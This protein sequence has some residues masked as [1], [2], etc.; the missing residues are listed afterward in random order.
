[1]RERRLRISA[2][3][4]VALV[5][6]VVVVGS[7]LRAEVPTGNPFTFELGVNSPTGETGKPF[8]V[9]SGAGDWAFFITATGNV[10]TLVLSIRDSSPGDFCWFWSKKRPVGTFSVTAEDMPAAV[11]DAC[12]GN[13]YEDVNGEPLVFFAGFQGAK[14]AGVK[15]TVAYPEP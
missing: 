5:S 2:L 4:T 3:L 12:P 11:L 6:G 7:V 13:Q 15:I 9:V 10:N 1:M 14:K 8:E